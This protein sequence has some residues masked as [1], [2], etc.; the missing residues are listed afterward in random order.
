VTKGKKTGGRN[1]SRGVSG[2]PDG[3]LPVPK[4][5]KKLRK[6]FRPEFEKSYKWTHAIETIGKEM[7]N[8]NILPKEN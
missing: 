6:D 5:I 1:W 7:G 4:D 3:R 8:V 2:N